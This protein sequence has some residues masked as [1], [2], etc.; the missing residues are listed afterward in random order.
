MQMTVFGSNTFLITLTKRT[1]CSEFSISTN[2]SSR[3]TRSDNKVRE[4][5]IVCL[6]WQQWT[7]TSVLFD[8]DGISV[9]HS[10]V[11]VGI[12]L[13]LSVLVCRCKNF[14]TSIRALSV[15]EFLNSAVTVL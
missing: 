15:R 2:Y 11:A 14:G 4:L 5:A 9:F 1:F 13:F 12:S 10:W 8:D 7:E 6:P 3:H